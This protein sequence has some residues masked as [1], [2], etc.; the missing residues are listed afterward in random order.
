MNVMIYA[1]NGAGGRRG[2]WI[3]FELN[4]CVYKL[5]NHFA[6]T[7][8]STVDAS[9]IVTASHIVNVIQLV[10][11]LVVVEYIVAQSTTPALALA[12]TI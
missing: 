3:G 11:L 7:L 4:I 12:V 5:V 2:H 10:P 9:A 6:C 8:T 1:A